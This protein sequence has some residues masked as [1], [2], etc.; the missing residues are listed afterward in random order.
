MRTM[1]S[2]SALEASA[3]VDAN[4]CSLSEIVVTNTGVATLYLQLFESAT[5]P[6]DT[7]VADFS[8]AV[9]AGQTISWS[10]P[11]QFGGG[12]RLSALS[13]CLSS[14]AVT[15]TVAGAVGAFYVFGSKAGG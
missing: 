13:V 1:Y 8:V 6:A 15:K 3:V 10:A 14:T 9:P 7:T 12:I 11:S 5:V 4:E 2:S